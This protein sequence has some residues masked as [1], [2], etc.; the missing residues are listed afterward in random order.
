MNIPAELQERPQWVVWKYG[1]PDNT[2]KLT[3]LPYD[4]KND[5]MAKYCLT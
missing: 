5:H 1:R 4:P 3:K 2:G